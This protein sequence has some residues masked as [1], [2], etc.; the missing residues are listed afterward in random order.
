MSPGSEPVR[1]NWGCGDH[2]RLGWINSDVKEGSGV[3]LVA[4]IRRGL[5][6]ASESVDCAVS[7]HALPELTYPE[8]VPA[9]EELLRVLK[10]RGVLRL[11]LPDLDKAAR[12]Y[13]G[14]D[15]GYFDLVAADAVT[16][17]GRFVT[18]ILWYGY[19]RSLFTLDFATE[20]LEKAG[21]VEIVACTAHQT[22]SGVAE[23]VELDNREKESFYIE[24][25][26]PRRRSKWI[27]GRYTRRP[28]M[29]AS[30]DVTA[31]EVT[32]S[33]SG[34]DLFDAHLDGPVVG[35]QFEAD[36]LRI[37]GWVV[38]KRSPAR[39]VEVVSD[40][41]VVGRATVDIPRQG[42]ADKYTG[43][44]GADTAGFDL[45]LSAGGRGPSELLVSVVL[46]DGSRAELGLIK[47]NVTRQGVLSRFFR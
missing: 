17:G 29:P 8:L 1:L 30:I 21:F 13:V 32:G 4:D 24:G 26:R 20:L 36:G 40:H 43:I 19:S 15:D 12:A 3:D 35:A 34:D 25:T 28:S 37:V 18:Q 2:T 46:E 10:P 45:T 33:S 31:V 16:P 38:G 27:F 23:I 44:A 7:V 14:G 6:L 11:V 41:D 47:V 42:V 5:P 22:A 39:E 9:L